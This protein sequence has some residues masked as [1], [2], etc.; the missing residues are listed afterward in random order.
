MQVI[1]TGILILFILYRIFKRV[2]RNF[3]WQPL[4]TGKM[5]LSAVIF[6]LLG[7]IFLFY[8]ASHTISLISDAAGILIGGVLAYYGAIT[9]R[10]EQR[11]GELY[12]RPNSWIGST[13]TVLFFARLIYRFYI[14]F[15]M[16]PQAGGQGGQSWSSGLQSMSVGWSSG[17]IFVMFAYYVAYNLLLQRKQKQQPRISNG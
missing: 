9:T 1:I 11:G 7:A 2:R 16:A 8:G 15:T 4:N 14:V 13:V 10:F 17:L 12:Y 3:G 6:L 5:Q